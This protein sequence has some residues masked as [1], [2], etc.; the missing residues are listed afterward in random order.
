MLLKLRTP[1]HHETIIKEQRT[2]FEREGKSQRQAAKEL[3][4][5]QPTV[6]R[7]L[8]LVKQNVSKAEQNVSPVTRESPDCAEERRP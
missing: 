3:G 6:R 1:D 2:K 7:D 4:V 5:T 8:G